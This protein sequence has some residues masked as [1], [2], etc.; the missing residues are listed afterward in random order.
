M[1]GTRKSRDGLQGGGFSEIF[2][3]PEL[4]DRCWDS[5][6]T[7]KGFIGRGLPDVTA[8]ATVA[9]GAK[10]PRSREGERCGRHDLF[11]AAVWAG[12]IA[13]INQ[14]LRRNL[15]YLNPLLYEEIGPQG[16]LRS[17]TKGDNKIGRLGYSAGPGWN[18][19]A[20]WGSPDGTKL[21]EWLQAHPHAVA[22]HQGLVD[23]GA[24]S[25]HN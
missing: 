15:G 4:A 16:I 13:L 8:T 12:L 25:A 21:L 23:G 5:L 11:P 10:D 14:G 3:R 20:G 19:V 22:R 1:Y 17:V 18:P 9:S 24:D 2:E 7:K 6:A